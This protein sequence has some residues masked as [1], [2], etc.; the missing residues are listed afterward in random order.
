[1]YI[2]QF[3]SIYES[4]RSNADKIKTELSIEESKFAKTLKE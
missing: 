1:M 3:S 4:V 2:D